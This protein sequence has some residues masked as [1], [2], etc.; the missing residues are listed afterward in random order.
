MEQCFL[1]TAAKPV[2][3]ACRELSIETKCTN[4][5]EKERLEGPVALS[6]D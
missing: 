3:Q 6:I 4:H 5:H 2:C 1:K